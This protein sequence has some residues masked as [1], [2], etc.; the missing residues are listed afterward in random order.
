MDN[1]DEPLQRKVV[2]ACV[3]QC[4]GTYKVMRLVCKHFGQLA[5]AVVDVIKVC[6]DGGGH[7]NQ[8]AARQTAGGFE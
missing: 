5:D 2:A 4:T 7:G 1:L 3:H 8:P 6:R